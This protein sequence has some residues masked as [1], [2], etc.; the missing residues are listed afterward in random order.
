MENNS[1]TN[2]VS[3][4]NWFEISSIQISFPETQKGEIR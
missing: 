2:K 1:E 4:L 3:E